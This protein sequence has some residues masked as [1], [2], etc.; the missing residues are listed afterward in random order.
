MASPCEVL[1]DTFDETL[2]KQLTSIAAEEAWRIESKFSRYNSSNIIHHIHTA[3]GEPVEV[4]DE[5]CELL[6]FADQCYKL[7][8]GLFDITSGILR[9]IWKFDGSSNIPSRKQAKAYLKRIGW[10][11]VRWQAP[12]LT[13]PKGMEI[14]LGGFGKEYAVDSAAK[15]VA[16]Q[17]SAAFLINF[18]GDIYAN[19]PPK[20]QDSWRIGLEKNDALGKANSIL[21][22]ASGAVATS[23]DTRRY[24]EKSGIRF[25]HVLNPKTAWPVMR[26]PS[27]VTVVADNCT[28]AGFLATMAMLKGKHADEFLAAQNV[29]YSLQT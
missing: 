23:G 2:A 21:E 25:P 7:S 15:N 11:E 4:D 6:N 5:F 24:L 18:G 26:A 22:L 13:L 10:D 12:F 14:D 8:D 1:I 29:R 16:D 17:S 19:K 27:S 9:E 28:S 20:E 3:Q